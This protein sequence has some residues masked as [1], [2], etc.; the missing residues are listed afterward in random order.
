ML[1]NSSTDSPG[2]PELAASSSLGQVT[3]PSAPW[4]LGSP[5]GSRSSRSQHDTP[6]PSNDAVSICLLPSNAQAGP[7]R[8]LN[9]APVVKSRRGAVLSRGTCAISIVASLS[10]SHRPHP[11]E[12]PLCLGCARSV[13]ADRRSQGTGRASD[14][15]LCL[16]GAPNF[17][18]G[19]GD[20]GVYGCAQPT[21]VGLR[22]VLAALGC[23]A[24][25]KEDHPS[26][27][28]AWICTREEPLVYVASR[29]YVLR[30][31]TH[32]KRN[33]TLSRRAEN[34]ECAFA[35]HQSHSHSKR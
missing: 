28:L 8:L 27:P 14:L 34:L 22:T 4:Q 1:A 5:Q 3:S 19:P 32:P 7:S 12:R 25:P 21:A 2:T 18:S 20:L 31:A 26:T 11:Q 16:Q 10:L 33:L 35:G 29:P 9:P 30:E 17:R 24:A 6:R 13:R 23:V 15:D